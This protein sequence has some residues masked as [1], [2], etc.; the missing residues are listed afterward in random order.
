MIKFNGNLKMIVDLKTMINRLQ[1]QLNNIF[2][3]K[4][5]ENLK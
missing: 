2:K 1:L 3:I 4:L 5:K